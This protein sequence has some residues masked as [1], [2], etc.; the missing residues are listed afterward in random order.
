M[1]VAV[2]AALT[3]AAANAAWRPGTLDPS[4][5]DGGTLVRGFGIVPGSGGA[6]EAAAMPDGGFLVRTAGG[7][8]GRYLADGHLDTRFGDGGYLIGG[9]A[10]AIATTAGG[11]IYV[12]G[13]GRNGAELSRLLPDS[14]PDPSFGRGRP[15]GLGAKAPPVEAMLVTPGG[16]V[17]LA[18]T[19]FPG[20]QARV[21]A[22][23]VR[24][25]G[26]VNRNY[27]D[28]GIARAV[29]PL[30][31][32]E[33][34]LFALDGDRLTFVA[35]AKS[36]FGNDVYHRELQL[37][38]LTAGGAVDPSYARLLRLRGETLDGPLSGIAIAPGHEAVVA[39]EGGTYARLSANGALRAD[40]ALGGPEGVG[41]I[42]R[43]LV[44]PPVVLTDGRIVVGGVSS[45]EHEPPRLVAARLN[46]DGSLDRS[47]GGGTGIVTTGIAAEAQ[48]S[49]LLVLAD[50]GLLLSGETS[51]EPKAILAARYT[52]DGAPE[53][54][55]GADGVLAT[56]PLVHSDDR[57]E[58]TAAGPRG[59]VVATGTAG[60]RLVVAAYGAN[61]R[62]D[63]AWADHG[64][65]L[66]PLDVTGP[67]TGS[68]VVRYLGGRTLVGVRSPAGASLLMLGP[69]GRPDHSFGRDGTVE[70]ADFREV[71]E[72]AVTARGQVL[73]AGTSGR[74]CRSLVERFGRGGGEDRGFGKAH[75]RAWVAT[76]C[77]VTHRSDLVQ[78]PDG[79]FVVAVED[80]GKI[81][82]FGAEG[83][84][85][86]SFSLPPAT[87]AS[88]PQRL[89]AIALDAHGR[90][91]VGGTLF[92]RLGLAR[93][94]RH[95][96]LDR[97]FGRNGAATR[98]VGREA[99]VTALRVEAGGRIFAAGYA[100]ICPAL[101]CRGRTALLARFDTDG[102]L[103][104]GFGRNGVWSGRR[105]GGSLDSLLLSG[106]GSLLAGG[107][108][109]R[110][111]NRDLMLVEV[112][113]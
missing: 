94:D 105:E 13:Y 22:M 6:V 73:V 104:P 79:S 29:Y 33:H 53:T 20:E 38:R 68:A 4:F 16:G 19:D 109:I 26:S 78:R 48:I 28:G 30:A 58:A 56:A 3:P 65:L 36:Y 7:S 88:L 103:D 84:P 77:G 10:E 27:G 70:L 64:V 42:G 111:G 91:L 49:A 96:H 57:V 8:I 52:A 21:E 69:D 98:E 106:P 95:G 90:L 12:L 101:E 85:S 80:T 67:E 66:A 76:A 74:P 81:V 100:N 59:G 108:S 15:T 37:G 34:F 46:P 61:G 75:G 39:A 62:P 23:R 32:G 2:L 50:G 5:A 60:G 86:P 47:F 63:P 87:Y 11:R 45:D 54:R 83:R 40:S 43:V 89:G 31:S 102:A 110:G 72:L 41:P 112:R 18:G 55:F 82:A 92:H 9:E 107:W 25:D 35:Q 97:S 1:F 24:A 71:G 14:S 17:V 51:D 99:R 113:R 44:A 93:L